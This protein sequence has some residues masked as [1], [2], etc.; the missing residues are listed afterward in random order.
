LQVDVLFDG[1]RRQISDGRG[2]E[3]MQIARIAAADAFRFQ[4]RE[5]QQLLN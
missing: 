2:S 1:G 4:P 3:R 5:R